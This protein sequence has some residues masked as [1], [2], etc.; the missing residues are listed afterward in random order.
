MKA[1]AISVKE[2]RDS[3][4]D[5]KTVASGLLYGLVG[6]IAVF[7]IIAITAAQQDT[8]GAAP[9]ALCRPADAPSLLAHL[10]RA[11]IELVEHAEICLDIPAELE[12]RLANGQAA[13]VG[14]LADLTRPSPTVTAVE[15]E[16]RAF[17][18]ERAAQ[19]LIARG[20]APSVMTPVS[21]DVQSTNPVSRVANTFGAVVVI[22]LV[23]TPFIVA[24]GMAADVTAGERERHSLE[25]LLAT[26]T[27]ASEIVLGKFLAVMF[28]NLAGTALCVVIGL[29]ILDRSAL[30]ALG[31]RLD[32]G[33][34][35]LLQ[36]VA[37]LAPLSVLVAA[38][39][40]TVGFWSKGFKD[41]QNTLMMLTLVP[42]GIGYASLGLA[43]P[44]G[45]W[46]VLW[47]TSALAR[48]LFNSTAPVAPFV[49]VAAIELG[50]AALLLTLAARRL[51]A[52][53]VLARA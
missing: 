15:R 16:I 12:T 22:F 19:R 28:F 31:V 46:P 1:I 18:G 11:G 7:Y 23:L 13:R 41:A 47:E 35:T 2:L 45:P 38:I 4:R 20:M 10:A 21:V 50:L 33:P 42:M 6:P 40:V 53:H 17:S 14:L 48:P 25:F 26:P 44:V 24:A 29:S 27:R 51:K 8:Q 30:P 32:A 9:V 49:L 39:E 52:S 5:R 34:A 36:V 3:L 37:W 43:G